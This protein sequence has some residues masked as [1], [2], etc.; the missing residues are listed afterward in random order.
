MI[1]LKWWNPTYTLSHIGIGLWHYYCKKGPYILVEKSHM[2][3]FFKQY[4]E[5]DT[6]S[7][8][9]HHR[10]IYPVRKSSF[11]TGVET[12]P[13]TKASRVQKKYFK[14]GRRPTRTRAVDGIQSCNLLPR[15]YL[16]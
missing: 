4:Y 7:L 9:F 6:K 15:T 12:P 11:S 16:P 5:T 14:P 1:F 3:W 8:S 13:G 10:I 2:Y